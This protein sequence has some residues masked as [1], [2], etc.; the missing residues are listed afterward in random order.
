MNTFIKG[1]KRGDINVLR[2]VKKSV[3]NIPNKDGKTLLMVASFYGH[4]NIVKTLLHNGANPLLTDFHGY[5]ALIYATIKGYIEIVRLLLQT[6]D[7]NVNHRTN[8]S[9][10]A[11]TFASK[12]GFYDI[13]DLLIEHNCRF[14]LKDGSGNTPLM[15]IIKHNNLAYVEKLLSL[16]LDLCVLCSNN[17]NETAKNIAHSRGYTELATLLNI[18]MI[19]QKFLMLCNYN[20]NNVTKFVTKYGFKFKN[21]SHVSDINSKIC[22]LLNKHNIFYNKL[23][24]IN[25]ISLSK[26]DKKINYNILENFNN[27]KII[28][29]LR[30][31]NPDGQISQNKYLNILFIYIYLHNN[32]NVHIKIKRNNRK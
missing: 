15:H 14:D 11:L 9:D 24:K 5:T 2:N 20:L 18:E 3:L 19:Y 12:R 22:S 21:G 30:K 8:I 16:P 6:N 29:I 25:I 1:I 27:N 10:N 32:P 17:V 26:S 28:N 7:S 4:T 23:I 13:I 31:L